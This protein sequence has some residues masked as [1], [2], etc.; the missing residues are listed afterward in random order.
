MNKL[1]LKQ[2][3]REEM[4]KEIFG[5][6]RTKPKTVEDIADDLKGLFAIAYES[7]LESPGSYD[8]FEEEFWNNKKQ[9]II[10]RL[11]KHIK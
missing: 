5:R 1:D 10:M 11:D 9:D 2:L 7:G 4:Q 8:D 6:S 3:I